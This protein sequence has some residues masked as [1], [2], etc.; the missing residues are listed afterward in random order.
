MLK[1][2]FSQIDD[3]SK[4]KHPSNL[5]I[6]YKSLGKNGRLGNQIWQ[7]LGTIHLAREIQAGFVFPEWSYQNAFSFPSNFFVSHDS[8]TFR[9]AIDSPKYLRYLKG[10]AIYLQDLSLLK[11]VAFDLDDWTKAPSNLDPVLKS[12]SSKYQLNERHA[13]HV[14]RGDYLSLSHYHTVPQ[15]KWFKDQI[16]PNTIIFTD[17]LDWC[18]ENFPGQEIFLGDEITTFHSMK[19]CKE[20]TISASSFSWWAAFLSKSPQVVYPD[21]WARVSKR[22]WDTSIFIPDYF[23]GKP[24]HL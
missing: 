5:A 19:L 15:L 10:Q 9:D 1:Y 22:L 4:S 6:S 20:F 24:V 21:P 23:Q 7:I 14:R 3:L 13:M 18:R 12:L 11:N 2:F 16:K 8:V 17:D